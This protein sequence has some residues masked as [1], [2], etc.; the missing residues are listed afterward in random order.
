MSAIQKVMARLQRTR[1]PGRG[2]EAGS[3]DPARDPG[4]LA[5][6]PA[7]IAR[8]KGR[9]VT[10]LDSA[11][12]LRRA[13]LTLAV[14]VIMEQLLNMA[15]MLVD[16]W[17]VGHL[18]ASALAAAGLANQVVM[19]V[20][21]I[22][23]AIATGSTA[24]VARR[25]GARDQSR[26]NHALGQSIILGVVMGGVAMGLGIVFAYQTIAWLGAAPDVV[27]QG[28]NYLIV[29]SSS[30]ILLAVLNIGNA[31]LRGAGDTRM[32]M[33]IMAVVNVVN[34]VA[35][36]SLIHGAAGLPALGVAGSAWGGSIAR[37]VGGLLVLGVLLSGRRVLRL[38]GRNVVRVDLREMGRIVNIGVPA[39]LEQA[40]M[41]LAQ[42][43]FVT[44]ITGLGTAAYAAYQVGITALSIAFMPGFAFAVSATTIV[45][46]GLGMR[47][48]DLSEAGARE[49]WRLAT[50]VMIVMGAVAFLF[51]EFLLRV[52]TDDAAVIEV[53]TLPLRVAAFGMPGLAA[54]MVFSGGLR[55][56][57]DTWWPLLITATSLWLVRTFGGGALVNLFGLGMVG[58]WVAVD[59]DMTVRGVLFWWRFRLGRWKLIRL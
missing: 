20:S 37:G 55:G 15:V 52:F 16:T 17:L 59:I 8:R 19:L 7:G 23:M 44:F 22:F 40:A 34:I 33:I 2:G 4:G 51:P 38:T 3:P 46:Q 27:E 21:A 25:I 10:L 14:P 53:G 6:A 5:G 30:L 56:A 45:G 54:S 57:G 48:P 50:L 41:R 32:P 29:S 42:L 58:A 47:R 43:V 24:L 31:A 28:G 1:E 9:D 18:G 26:A 35:A 11:G 49:S 13:V 36:Y 12:G 39:G